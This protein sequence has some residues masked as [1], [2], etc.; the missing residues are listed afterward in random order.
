MDGLLFAPL[1][2]LCEVIELCAKLIRYR[3]VAFL[4]RAENYAEAQSHY[5]ITSKAVV[6]PESMGMRGF[7]FH[8]LG[9]VLDR[10]LHYYVQHI[11]V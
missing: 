9:F 3:G 1:R 2:T 4:L 11:E 10:D 5:D 8:D 6:H 7:A